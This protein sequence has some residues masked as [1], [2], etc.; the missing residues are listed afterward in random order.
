[1]V[2]TSYNQTL[3]ATG[4]APITW[5]L[6]SDSLPNG[7]TLSEAGLISGT[8]N[9]GGRFEFLVQA[10]KSL[11]NDTKELCIHI[12]GVGVSENEMEDIVIF[13][14]PTTGEL[15]IRNYELGIR[16]IEVFDVYGRKLSQ[17]S[18]PN[19]QLSY[20][21]DIFHLQAGIYFVKITMEKGIVIKKV[22]KL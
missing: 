21:I 8:P 9:A 19:S 16:N 14:N 3:T 10:T 1:M 13:P 11:G 20:L 22:I 2:G 5:S 7:L 17:I 12:D 6:E 4:T 18:Y 15:G